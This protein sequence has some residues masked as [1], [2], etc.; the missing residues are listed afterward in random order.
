M[1]QQSMSLVKT[2]HKGII[3]INSSMVWFAY[4]SVKSAVG[5]RK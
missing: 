1:S 4:S 5:S 3:M 2:E